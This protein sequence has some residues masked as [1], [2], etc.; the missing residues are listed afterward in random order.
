MEPSYLYSRNSFSGKRVFLYSNT[1]KFYVSIF[2][3]T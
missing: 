2:F 3:D 1:P